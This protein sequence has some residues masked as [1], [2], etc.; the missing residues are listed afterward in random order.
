MVKEIKFFLYKAFIDFL[1]SHPRAPY[2]ARVSAIF[3]LDT[4]SEMDYDRYVRAT[5]P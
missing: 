5:E 2:T 1:G 3:A 4:F